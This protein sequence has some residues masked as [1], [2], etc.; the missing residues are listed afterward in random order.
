MD[1]S[2]IL[3]D[4][5]TWLESPLA[6]DGFLEW[7]MILC[8][9]LVLII[10][11]IVIA[12]L[13][14]RRRR[15][16]R[17]A[18][19]TA[20]SKGTGVI[21]KTVKEPPKKKRRQTTFEPGKTVTIQDT[22]P[23]GPLIVSNL[24]GLGDRSEQQ[25]AFGMSLVSA[26]QAEGFTAVLCDGMGGMAD[27][28]RVARLAV[29][30]LLA[31]S[32]GNQLFRNGAAASPDDMVKH[33]AAKIRETS[34][35]IYGQLF[36]QGGSTLVMTYILRGQLY[37][38][39]LGDSD[40]FLMRG[41]RLYALN[42]RHEYQK[43]LLR[44]AAKGLVRTDQAFSDPQAAALMEY[45]GKEETDV[46]YTR[47]PLK[48]LKND[49]LLLCSDGISDSLT[50]REIESAMVLSPHGAAAALEERI[51]QKALIGQDNYTAILIQ[52]NE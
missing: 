46:E 41:G 7:W 49:R 42:E 37:F 12:V 40:L 8:A 20:Q 45:M 32:P 17:E 48:L 22:Q 2:A 21:S 33:T 28:A 23:Q 3:D 35:E 30:R 43:T 4:I 27:G 25:D 6:E 51:E 5:F 15:K 50:L 44:K 36:G 16:K 31:D 38:W 14:R 24:Q 26:Y 11:A 9:G 52:Y 47:R 29:D 39:T 1:L 19:G 18:A 13:V 10:L 34:K